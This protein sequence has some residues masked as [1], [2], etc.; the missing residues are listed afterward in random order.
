MPRCKCPGRMEVGKLAPY[1]GTGRGQT[2]KIA[3]HNLIRNSGLLDGYITLMKLAL[4]YECAGDCEIR[5]RYTITP[6]ATFNQDANGLWEAHFSDVKLA[7]SV[8]CV[9]RIEA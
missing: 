5:T 7:V 8:E 2:R 4:E 9:E 1:N 3:W 6:A